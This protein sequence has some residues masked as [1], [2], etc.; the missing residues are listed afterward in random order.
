M[1]NSVPL[2]KVEDLSISILSKSGEKSLTHEVSFELYEGE[3]LALVGESGS[4][5]SISSMACLGWLPQP[6]GKIVNGKIWFEGF[7]LWDGASSLEKQNLKSWQKI[8]GN[9]IALISQE[10]SQSLNPLV[11]I[12]KQLMEVF[13]IHKLKVDKTWVIEL[14][15]KVGLCKVEADEKRILKSYPWELSGGMQQRVSIAMALILRPKLLIADEPT[16]ALDVSVQSQILDLLEELQQEMKMGVLFI[17]HNLGLVARLADRLVVMQ[18]GKVVESSTV[19]DFFENP[20][21]EYSKALLEAV[22]RLPNRK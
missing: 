16:T 5:K 7:D 11:R 14:L 4:G 15:Y 10:P 2:L 6:G 18:N 22:P 20:K 17:T 9:Q 3:I 21:M 13:K 19:E 8:R 12:E 1:I